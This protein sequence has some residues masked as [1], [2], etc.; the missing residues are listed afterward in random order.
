MP[1]I[2]WL[3]ILIIVVLAVLIIGPKDFPIVIR[4]VGSWIG[5]VKGYFRNIQSE[6]DQFEDIIDLESKE[7]T[8]KNNHKEKKDTSK[9]FKEDKSE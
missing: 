7:L 4:K 1:Q 8:K 2:G 6:M 5:A 9:T 3:E